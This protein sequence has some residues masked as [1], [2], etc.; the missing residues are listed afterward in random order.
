MAMT[1]NK[2]KPIPIRQQTLSHFY[3]LKEYE[4]RAAIWKAWRASGLTVEKYL[5]N[6]K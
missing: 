2:E 1:C 5:K 6:R 3:R 4:W